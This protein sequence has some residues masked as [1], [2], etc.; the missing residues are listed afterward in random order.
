MEASAYADEDYCQTLG[1]PMAYQRDAPASLALPPEA[2]TEVNALVAGAELDASEF[3]WAVQRSEYCLLGT[4]VSALIHT[5]TGYSFRFEFLESSLGQ[6]RVSV[7]TSESRPN[8][9]R[10]AASW[11]DQLGH[12]R[13]WHAPADA[14]E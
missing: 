10:A 6:N 2:Q 14:K 12:V 1:G 9:R 4:L 13:E 5:P 8:G 11:E 3:T 7:F